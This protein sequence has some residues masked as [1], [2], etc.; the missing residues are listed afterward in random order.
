MGSE[1]IFNES[2]SY[3]QIPLSQIYINLYKSE[4]SNICLD[5]DLFHCMKILTLAIKHV[6]TYSR[7]LS[8]QAPANT[9]LL[10]DTDLPLTVRKNNC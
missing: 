1:Y 9:S 5:K 7:Q 10:T 6:T 8:Q 4:V 3:S 2:L